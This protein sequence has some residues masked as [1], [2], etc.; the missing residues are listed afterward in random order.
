MAP[1]IK[2]FS[3]HADRYDVRLCVTGQHR[4]MLRQTLSFF[5]LGAD[6][7]LDLMKPGQTLFDITARALTGLEGV[8]EEAR[9]DLVLVQGDTTTAFTGALAAFYK[10]VR[11]AHIEA[12]LRTDD[13]YSPFPEEMNRAL[14]SRLADLHFA[15]TPRAVENLA[16]EGLREHVYQVGNTVIDALLMSLSVVKERHQAAFEEEHP[17]VRSGRRII[18][19]TG[20]RRE[21]F[22]KPFEAICRALRAVAERFEDVE[23]VYPVHLNPQVRAPVDAL[24]RGTPRVHLLEPVEYPKL[25]WLLSQSHLVL[26]DSG[27]IQEEA[28]SLGRP[29]LVMREVTER[30]EGIEA[31]CAELVGTR[32]ESILEGVTRLLTDDARYARMAQ[33]QNPYGD[34]KSSEAIVRQVDAALG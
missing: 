26:T 32:E 15:P 17:F 12:G 25:V 18:L 27:G 10:K 23:L 31:G 7:D 34:G 29:V 16:K 5:G 33:A 19:I 21:S 28:P 24:L 11:V 22:G 9:P 4:E 13:R 6:Y 8:L 14:V 1:V 30:P 3:A 20:H 2:A